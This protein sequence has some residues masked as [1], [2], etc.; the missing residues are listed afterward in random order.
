MNGPVY[1]G[2]LQG[3]LPTKATGNMTIREGGRMGM[4]D[5]LCTAPTGIPD[6]F[7]PYAHAKCTAGA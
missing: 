4:C 2:V 5:L 6:P 1:L 3:L 7:E